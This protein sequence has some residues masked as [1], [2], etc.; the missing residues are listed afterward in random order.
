MKQA[1]IDIGTNTALL[2]IAEADRIAQMKVIADVHSIARLGER[3]DQTKQI[4]PHS[5]ERLRK[6]LLNYR[7]ILEEN[8]V[9]S[10]API[11]TSAM[12]DAVNRAEIINNAKE[13]CG[14]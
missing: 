3:V 9:D 5:Y 4:Q 1:V 12:R 11:A 10:V 6:I 13:E 2:L 14:F 8:K 7:G